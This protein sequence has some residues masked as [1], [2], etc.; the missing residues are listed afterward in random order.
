MWINPEVGTEWALDQAINAQSGR[1]WQRSIVRGIISTMSFF[2]Q[3]QLQ[4]I[5]DA[6][7]DTSEGLSG[8]EIAHLLATCGMSDP[9]PAMTKRHRLYNA[10]AESQNTRAD[11]A[12]V[13]A[14]IRKSMKPELYARSPERYEPMRATSIAPLFSPG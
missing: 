3:S 9:S 12:A 7:G 6:L 11:R 2:T 1:P 4:A 5:A 14:L 8:S 10:F 13:L